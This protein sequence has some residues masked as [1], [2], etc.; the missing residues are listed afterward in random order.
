MRV[1]VGPR[2]GVR[3][4]ISCGCDWRVGLP[5]FAGMARLL[6]MSVDEEDMWE[7]TPCMQKNSILI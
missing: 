6:A 2:W 4:S 3:L 1:G 7:S 5:L